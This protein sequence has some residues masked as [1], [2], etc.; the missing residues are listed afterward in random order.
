LPAPNL[1]GFNGPRNE[2]T[3]GRLRNTLAN[4]ASKQSVRFFPAELVQRGGLPG[5]AGKAPAPMRPAGAPVAGPSGFAG[6][7]GQSGLSN[8][9]TP[10]TGSLDAGIK[11]NQDAIQSLLQ[12]LQGMQDWK[13]PAPP[14]GQQPGGGGSQHGNFQVQDYLEVIRHFESGGNYQARS[15][16][17]S[18]SGAY[19]ATDATWGNYGGYGHAY[20]APKAVQDAWAR[21]HVAAIQKVYGVDPKWVPAAWFAGIYGAGHEDWDQIPG[22]GNNLTIQQYVNRWLQYLYGLGPPPGRQ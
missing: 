20:L 11:A 18:A 2:A 5:V 3:T 7:G 12:Q 1:S 21:Q 6:P 15:K 9:Y 14:A 8:Q 10:G 22:H 13:P 16:Y 4:L 17:S 19:Q